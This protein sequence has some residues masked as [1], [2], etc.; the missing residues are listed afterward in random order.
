[1][2]NV[3]R[4]SRPVSTQ[5]SSRT[6]PG[7]TTPELRAR[8]VSNYYDDERRRGSDPITAHN[9]S[10]AFGNDLERIARIMSEG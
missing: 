9:R 4:L 7:L 5:C 8:A 10:E 3:I 2:S 6:M 1:M